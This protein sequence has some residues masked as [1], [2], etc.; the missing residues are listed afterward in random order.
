M[1]AKY[2]ENGGFMKL[3]QCQECGKYQ[4]AKDW[5]ACNKHNTPIGM[6][7]VLKMTKQEAEGWLSKISSKTGH[8]NQGNNDVALSNRESLA[9]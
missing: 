9:T 7:Q 8:L 3:Y 5:V 4:E 6:A 2:F 1:S